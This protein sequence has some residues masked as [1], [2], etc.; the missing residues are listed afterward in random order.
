MSTLP[1]R[2]LHFHE[3]EKWLHELRVTTAGRRSAIEP[4]YESGLVKHILPYVRLRPEHLEASLRNVMYTERDQEVRT[5]C[6]EMLAMLGRGKTWRRGI[7]RSVGSALYLCCTPKACKDYL[8]RL[9]DDGVERLT[10]EEYIDWMKRRHDEDRQTWSLGGKPASKTLLPRSLYLPTLAG[11][12]SWPPK[13]DLLEEVE[14]R[15]VLARDHMHLI[16]E[17]NG[18]PWGTM[19][20]ECSTTLIACQVIHS[21]PPTHILRACRRL[22][23]CRGSQ[24]YW[25]RQD[26]S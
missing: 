17:C 15:K 14:N 12:A 23:R 9:L 16:L 3:F 4:G 10:D 25:V 5:T 6:N 18:H 11:R 13:F 21:P 20:A 1:L 19:T 22:E 24:S 26:E 8:T 2:T 7:G